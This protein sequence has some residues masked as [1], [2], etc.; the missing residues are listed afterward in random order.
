[1]QNDLPDLSDR[2]AELA[3]LPDTKL[4]PSR[5]ATFWVACG[6]A[7]LL[8][9]WWI[10]GRWSAGPRGFPRFV[11]WN[12]LNYQADGAEPSAPPDADAAPGGADQNVIGGG[13]TAAE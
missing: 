2:L 10:R 8:G 13:A 5:G 3:A 4:R 9:A 11:E 12:G 1:M 7:A 6:L